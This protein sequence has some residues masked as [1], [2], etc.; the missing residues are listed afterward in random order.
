MKGIVP[1]SKSTSKSPTARGA[2]GA[3][4]GDGRASAKARSAAF[5]YTID[6]LA[7]E[8]GTTVRNV[9][10]YQDRELLP[11]PEKRGRTGIY[12]KAHLGRLK[13]I[14]Q[15][16]S[17]GYTLANIG[18][19]LEAL[20]RGHDL[21]QILGLEAAITSP[22]SEE[23]PAYFSLPDLLRMFKVPLNPRTLAKVIKLGILEP[24]GLRYRAPYPKILKAGAE[25]TRIGLSL[26]D[27]LAIIE[28][29][30][31]NVQRVADEVIKR[32]VG[33][34]D[35]YGEGKLPPPEDVPRLADM[36]WQLRPL[37]NMAIDAEVS[38]AM[39]KSIGEFFGDRVVQILEHIRE[40]AAE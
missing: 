32:I 10:A 17:R 13:L 21:R 40:K 6:E 22:W 28:L 19:L 33:I 39:D 30:R 18:E 31:E 37:A 36:I 38:R 3:A 14:G 16:L 12:S 20:E 4:R 25:L 27:M 23:I 1:S 2:A 7:R 15:L 8:A 26:D 29:L 5:E 24:D 34:L 11:P 9:R 35:Q